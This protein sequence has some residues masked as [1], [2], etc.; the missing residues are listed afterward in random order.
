MTPPGTTAGLL[1]PGH[2][3]SVEETH[4]C[5]TY[6]WRTPDQA[7]QGDKGPE[8]RGLS[9]LLAFIPRAQKYPFPRGTRRGPAA[10]ASTS[11]PSFLDTWGH[12]GG[13]GGSQRC[14]VDPQAQ[15]RARHEHQFCVLRGN[16]LRSCPPASRGGR[17]PGVWELG[18]RLPASC[19][20]AT[21]PAARQLRRAC[22]PSWAPDQQVW[23]TRSFLFYQTHGET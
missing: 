14:G 6:R 9:R 12:S 4:L 1:S 5:L 7:R 16:P 21:S 17:G 11:V 23:A 2:W 13:Q 22:P 3:Q 10:R 15:Q 20:K 19:T 18:A 8:Q